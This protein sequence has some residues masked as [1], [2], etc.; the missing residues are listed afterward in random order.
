MMAL[1][2]SPRPL[3]FA[4]LVAVTA[5]GGGSGTVPQPDGGSD[6][7]TDGGGGAS[8]R[9]LAVVGSA[10]VQVEVGGSAELR[11]ALIQDELGP[12][13]GETVT[14]TA[15]GAPADALIGGGVTATA[16][17][18]A[19][20][21]A[22]VPF[23]AG[24]SES[25]GFVVTA[26]APG[27]NQAG[28]N[29]QII[30]RQHY[31]RISKTPSVRPTADGTQATVETAAFAQVL[32]RVRITDQFGAPVSDVP[33]AFGF[34]SGAGA[35]SATLANA[36][37]PAMT[38]AGGEAQVTLDTGIDLSDVFQVTARTD[39]SPT[40][41]WN[42]SL[43]P[44]E[45]NLCT[46]NAECPAGEYCDPDKQVCAGLPTCDPSAGVD[47]CPTG[48]K[49][50]PG[51]ECVAVFS[52]GCVTATDCGDGYDCVEGACV[53]TTG[54]NADTC[55]GGTICVPASNGTTT[56]EPVP[57]NPADISGGWYTAHTFHIGESLPGIASD[58]AGPI[59]TIDRLFLGDLG[60][61][62]FLE[63]IIRGLV[64]E[65]V[66]DWLQDVVHILDN[67][68]TLLHDLRARGYM[69]VTQ[70]SKSPTWTATE[71]WDSFVFY[72][73][74]MCSSIPADPTPACARVDLMA[75]DP[76]TVAE[77]GLK[78]H[79]FGGSVSATRVV[80]NTREVEMRVAKLV[81]I[82]ADYLVSRFTPY[83]TVEDAIIHAVDCQA[84]A[85]FAEDTIGFGGDTVK[86]ACES[87]V[88]YAAGE[89]TKRLYDLAFDMGLLEF[90]GEATVTV[91]SRE[92]GKYLG[93]QSWEQDKDGSYQGRFTKVLKNVP[94]EWH[95][96]RYA[97][98]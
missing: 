35:K 73:L 95:A 31:I 7:G 47:D 96:S 87:G 23:T 81:G 54:C 94:G 38:G 14:F 20:G 85:D 53:G 92:R 1:L 28:F 98:P 76:D 83:D 10:L 11:V 32:L 70:A 52:A 13:S 18:D 42:V 6:P 86:S 50:A 90:D 5:C 17:T 8:T 16:V 97:I 71:L 2:R 4:L 82:L 39:S 78:V 60:L 64:D 40:A 12:V 77:L 51:G 68:L 46:S 63:D 34:K 88:Q 24:S 62:G 43:S 55:P 72:Y 44:A 69:E 21:V 59:R 49:C 89:V 19:Q 58:L 75:D 93:S 15:I 67:V 74:D 79:D 41:V 9:R 80:V 30:K 37:T 26:A 33:V 3:I 22:S 56:C 84:V 57:E 29:V 27:A 66:P 45:V 91:G 25:S 48:Y 61:P 65:Y 36:G